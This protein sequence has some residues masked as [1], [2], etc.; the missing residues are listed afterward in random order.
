MYERI[1]KRCLD[2]VAAVATLLLL[3]PVMLLIALA[4]AIEDR[5]PALFRQRRVGRHGHDFTLFKF[6]SMPVV[7]P[8]LP[9]A[10]AGSLTVTRV[11]RFIRRSNLDELPHLL[12]VLRG[13]MSLIGPRP[14]LRSQ[15]TLLELRRQADV[16]RARPGLTGLAQVNSYDGM[17][18][19]EKVQWESRYVARITFLGDVMIVLATLRYLTRPPPVY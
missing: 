9:S 12:N 19:T 4:I 2:V 18:E 1:F 16:L 6:R 17:P 5:G 14:A 11:G 10:A 3:A 15:T 7:T 13:E 8:D